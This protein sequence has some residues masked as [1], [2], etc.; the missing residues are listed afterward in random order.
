M[1][2]GHTV[3]RYNKEMEGLHQLVLQMT[4]LSREQII[5]AV[6]SLEN[7]NL[8]LANEVVERDSE[9][10]DFDTQSTL[11]RLSTF[12]M[13][14]ARSVGH[15]VMQYWDYA[16]LKGWEAMPVILRATPYF[17]LEVKMFSMNP[18][19]KCLPK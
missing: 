12:V 13:E 8:S 19:M 18:L 3:Q 10:N 4:A 6:D 14:D 15:M 16:Q 1:A 5:K 9:I 2:E 7:E 11:R 17:L